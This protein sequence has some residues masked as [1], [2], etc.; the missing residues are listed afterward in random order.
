[1]SFRTEKLSGGKKEKRLTVLLMANMD[2]SDKSNKNA[3]M[4]ATLFQ[5]WVNDFNKFTQT[6]GRKVC[7]LLDNCSA[8]NIE[9]AHLKCVKLVYLLQ[10]QR[11]LF[12]L[13]TK[14]S[15]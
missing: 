7:S 2:G 12:N 15:S 3:W 8:H 1:M 4:T 10:T 6:K 13:W 9:K 14:E 5:N 11:H